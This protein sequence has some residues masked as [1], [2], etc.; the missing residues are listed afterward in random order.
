MAQSNIATSISLLPAKYRRYVIPGAIALFVGIVTFLIIFTTYNYITDKKVEEVSTLFFEL[1]QA[2]EAED[3]NLARTKI[4]AIKNTANDD[5]YV[6]AAMKLAKFYFDSDDSNSAKELY[7]EI[8]DLSS[9]ETIRDIARV[10]LIK[11]L[12]TENNAEELETLFDDLEAVS[13]PMQVYFSVLQ[14]DINTANG[15]YEDAMQN[16]Q[17]A[18]EYAEGILSEDLANYVNLKLNAA[19]SAKLTSEKNE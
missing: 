12:F 10:R 11:I 3:A 17:E 5:Q 16:Y 19:F 15:N 18:L 6:I 14:G 7:Y 9:E 2:I 8:I 1:D 4:V 13:N